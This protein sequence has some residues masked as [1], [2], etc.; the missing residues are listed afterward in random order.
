MTGAVF[1]LGTYL[2]LGVA[3]LLTCRLLTWLHYRRGSDQE[4][5][6]L[7]D[8]INEK[9]QHSAF[10]SA[11]KATGAYALIVLVWPLALIIVAWDMLDG[12][13]DGRILRREP[14]PE[15][16]FFAKGNLIEKVN[17]PTAEEREQVVD[18]SGRAPTQPFGHLNNG[19]KAFLNRQ[20]SEDA[21][22]WS[23]NRAS[24]D[25]KRWPFD[26]ANGIGRGYCWVVNGKVVSEI[27]VE[28]S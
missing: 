22:L 7:L 10:I 23:F 18:P 21:E 6:K 11:V 25:K 4:T 17:I 9:K 3:A 13:R 8:A 14:D 24:D 1:Y 2:G 28:G 27:R 20:P 12:V 5:L 26:R 15:D 16:L 19:W